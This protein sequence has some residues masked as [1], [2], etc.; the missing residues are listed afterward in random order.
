L[1]K[2]QLFFYEKISESIRPRVLAEVVFLIPLFA[3]ILIL[4][5]LWKTLTGVGNYL[6]QLFG[7]NSGSDTHTKA[8]SDKT[9][10]EHFFIS[11]KSMQSLAKV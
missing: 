7:L 4:Q 9:Q 5:K 11:K 8:T 3:I 1:P 2:L 6:V 10:Y